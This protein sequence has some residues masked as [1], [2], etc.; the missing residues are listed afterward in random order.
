MEKSACDHVFVYGTLRRGDD[1]DLTRLTPAPRYV[2][3]GHIAGTMYHMGPYPGVVGGGTMQVFGEVYAVT[4]A[5]QDELDRIEESYGLDGDDY[6]KADVMVQ[7]DDG[8]IQAFAY[9]MSPAC[10][11]EHP[12]ITS[13]DWIAD[14]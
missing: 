7:T 9:L 2:C 4:R 5:M 11:G 1:N 13:G 6:F 12:V 8:L 14:R 10:I 3:T